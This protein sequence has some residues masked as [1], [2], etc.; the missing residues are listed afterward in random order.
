MKTEAEN[1]GKDRTKF[2]S[3]NKENKKR[4]SSVF[5]RDNFVLP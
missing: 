3:Q 5:Y 1:R 4:K 2:T